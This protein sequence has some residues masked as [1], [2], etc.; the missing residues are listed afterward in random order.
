MDEGS[1]A[2]EAFSEAIDTCGLR[3]SS[4]AK[5]AIMAAVAFAGFK[6]F[7][8][9]VNTIDRLDSEFADLKNSLEE[10]ATDLT[11]AETELKNTKDRMEEL[12]EIAGSGS[13][14]IAEAEELQL[15]EEQNRALERKINLLRQEQE[16]KQAY[17]TRD[18]VSLMNGDLN[19]AH[20]SSD[21]LTGFDVKITDGMETLTP[22]YDTELAYIEKQFARYKDNLAKIA[23]EES[24]YKDDIEAAI[25][26]ENYDY[27]NSLVATQEA[28]VAK[29]KAENKRILTYLDGKKT[30]FETRA[31]GLEYFTGENL[32][33]E[34]IA[35]NEQL[36][37]I[38]DFVDKRAIL[39]GQSGAKTDAVYRL[40]DTTFADTTAGL[41]EM[42]KQGE[43]TAD[44]LKDPAYDLFLNKCIELGII[45]DKT[46]TSLAFIA[47]AF[48]NVATAASEAGP[49]IAE[50]YSKMSEAVAKHRSEL[51]AINSA[52]TQQGYS[53][54]LSVESYEA[55][56][57]ASA[58]YAACVEY[59]N[60]ALQLNT[61]RAT[62]LF[63]A[64]NQLKIT[65]IE[66]QKVAEATKWR[67]NAK[68]ISDLENQTVS[69][70]D[71]QVAQLENLKKENA[72]IERNITGYNVQIAAL[73]ELTSAYTKWRS[74]S[75]SDNS[76]TMY[77]DMASAME[78]IRAGLESGKTGVGNVV[79]QA[80]VELLV[81]DKENVS[82]YMD[83]LERYITEDASGLSNFISDMV[84]SGLME[85]AGD[86]VRMKAGVTIDQICKDLTITP[87]MAKAIFNAL[88]MYEGWDFNWSEEDFNIKPTMDTAE[89]DAQIATLQS[90]IDAITNGEP[91]EIPAGESLETLQ[92]K[93][94][95]LNAQKEA[96][97]SSAGSE[98][99]ENEVVYNINANTELADGA[100]ESIKSK[101]DEIA[102]KVTAVAAMAIGDLGGEA[103]VSVLK[104]VYGQLVA[105]NSYTIANKSYTVTKYEQ[106]IQLGGSKGETTRL[107]KG[108][109]S[110]PGGTA[111][112]GDEYSPD[113]SP[114]PEL[115]ISDG[116]AYLAGLSGPEL[117]N[118]DAGDQVLTATETRKVLHGNPS[119]RR[120]AIP[121]YAA[122]IKDDFGGTKKTAAQIQK[123]LEAAQ[124]AAANKSS[125]SSNGSTKSMVQMASSPSKYVSGVGSVSSIGGGSSSSKGSGG[126]GSGSSGSSGSSSSGG[127][128][129]E[130]SAFE[131]QYD[132]HQHLLAM[133]KERTENYLKWLESA[134]KD[135]YAQ[136]QIELDDFYKYEEEVFDLKK[137]IFMDGLNDIEHRISTLE[138]EGGSESQIINLYNQMISNLDQE[139]AAA[140]ARGL[141][142][143][144]EYIQELLEQKYDYVDEIK[145][146]QDE[147]TENAKDALDDLV[148]YRIDMLKQDIENEKDA[149][150]DKIDTLKEFYDKQKEML[151]DVYDE[152]K[153]LEQQ[154]EKR[155]TRD[156][157]KAELEQ[158]KFDNS[159]WAEKRKLELQEEL[160][161]AE[162][163]LADFE[164]DHAYENAQ[165]LLDKM[166]E[167]Q[168]SQLQSQID[169][170]DKRLNDPEALYNQALR[171][172]Q[173]NTLGLY[174]EMIEYNNKYGS[175]NS[176]DIYDKWTGADEALD[177]YFRTMGQAFKNILLVDAYKPSGYASGT[178]H[179]SSGVHELFEKGDEYVYTTSD[180][181]R[182]RMFSGLGEKVLN[183]KATN[184]LYDFANSG[185]AFISSLLR[186]FAS[187]VG[188]GSIMRHN[189][190]IQLS[191]GD[192]IIQGNATERT[193]SEI[194][195]AQRDNINYVLHEFNRLGK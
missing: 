122:G 142:D 138:R 185:E 90:Q 68:A 54:N 169:E 103:A 31:D 134:Y 168:E 190:P 44:S 59:Q 181:K 135:A 57:A 139:I 85:Q 148:D 39:L 51:E 189:Q 5:Y 140:R 106:T 137:D 141:N 58:D 178:S 114:K 19:S 79:Y 76:D 146:I 26:A 176:A 10:V 17:I 28:A 15:L 67:E 42:G 118:L 92:S 147:I 60:G 52:T 113:G 109:K 64:K 159:A 105:I 25:D 156:Q 184:F 72:V 101:L 55:L 66:L 99:V 183:A 75:E 128:S 115:V 192:I 89:L 179:A 110:A 95:N 144:D 143:S 36:S 77:S 186:T 41:K 193:V 173:N 14:T 97:S 40:M 50:S 46:D 6:L 158:L 162:K 177:A 175:G 13:L 91:V 61:E 98:G 86:Q 47:T 170:L 35:F 16:L 30:E 69:L 165:D 43:V 34:Q 94:D 53:G 145:D 194:R 84:S 2:A 93:L 160:L 124:K 62:K 116:E 151:Q 4:L 100:L 27:A 171:D 187:N 22:V 166:Y 9:L 120:G 161:E 96:L 49:K 111:L 149:V 63:D 33:Q 129:K 112:L 12:T 24:K 23:D 48:N 8:Y 29:F 32:T 195:R 155:K 107:A 125:T 74:V 180:G 78:D 83:T 154:S 104:Q 164:K 65:E 56:I 3:L 182:Y 172:I 80:A 117:V 163:D 18:F 131:K 130:K 70:T 7:D 133:E 87:E 174:E 126:G 150:N 152:E 119:A 38:E 71:A 82:A 121:A 81:P 136:G 108:T 127:S 73:E 123:E 88:E 191:T 157:V 20:V 102:D 153:Y 37:Y 11:S 188:L 21:N 1:T 132:E 167:Q 45:A